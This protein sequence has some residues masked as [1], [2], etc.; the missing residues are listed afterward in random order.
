MPGAE[1]IER[2]INE[3]EN[4]IAKLSKAFIR[5]ETLLE[6]DQEI[7]KDMRDHMR[8]QTEQN[9]RLIAA[10]TKQEYMQ[11]EVDEL[12][13]A[14]KKHNDDGCPKAIAAEDIAKWTRGIIMKVFYTISGAVVLTVLALALTKQG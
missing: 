14:N 5:M 2:R 13:A 11:K 9:E 10:M 1:D 4:D 6:K 12:K 3:H 7:K 8:K